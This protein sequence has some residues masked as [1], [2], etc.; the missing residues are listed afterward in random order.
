MA[1]SLRSVRNGALVALLLG[2]PVMLLRSS[3]KDPH[4]MGAFD[5]AIRRIGGPLEAAVSYSFGMLGGFFERWVLQARL[6][7]ANEELAGENRELKQKMRDLAQLEEE[8][9]QLRRALQMR[10]RVPEDMIPAERVGVDQSPFFRVVNIRIDRG[11]NVAEPGMAVLSPDGVVGRIDKSFDDYS[12]VMLITDARSMV[13]VEVAR[14]HAQ[15]ILEGDSED[16]CVVDVSKDYEVQLGDIIQTSGVDE[17]FPKGHPV[18]QVVG[19]EQ[20][21]GDQQRLRVMPSVQFDRLDVVW[22]V[23]AAAPATDPQ[24]EHVSS[25]PQARGLVPIR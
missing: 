20:L 1:V 17:L 7:D 5:R 2:I 15:G 23:L 11:R 3:L 25:L 21:V 8:N 16:S 22:V 19:I 14:N 24:A 18:G 4:Q 10:E 9:T 12:D 6:Q 13:A